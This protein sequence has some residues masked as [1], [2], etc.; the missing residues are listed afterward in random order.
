VN[1][2]LLQIAPALG[3][4]AEIEGA[5]GAKRRRAIRRTLSFI[6]RNNTFS[7]T[8]FEENPGNNPPITA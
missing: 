8:K 3:G 7:R 2:A 5:R 1:P 4:V 6:E